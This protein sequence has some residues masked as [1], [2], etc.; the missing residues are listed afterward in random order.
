MHI[1]LNTWIYVAEWW[2]SCQHCYHATCQ[3]DVAILCGDCMFSPCLCGFSWRLYKL[4]VG[5]NV[6]EYGCVSLCVSPATTRLHD[7]GDELQP[8]V[9]LKRINSLCKFLNCKCLSLQQ[10]AVICVFFSFHLFKS[11][12]RRS[13]INN[14][15]QT[16]FDL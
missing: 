4:T 14:S 1:N 7:Q 3:S 5:L 6:S 2:R 15:R 11:S 10:C 13:I 8:H 16:T 12:S 9:T